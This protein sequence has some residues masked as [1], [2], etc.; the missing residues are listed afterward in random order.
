MLPSRPVAGEEHIA[1][2][3]TSV[4]GVWGRGRGAKVS[5]DWVLLRRRLSR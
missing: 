3:G 1:G 5:W 2:V 4:T